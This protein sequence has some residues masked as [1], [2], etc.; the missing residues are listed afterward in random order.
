MGLNF[1]T[2]FTEALNVK[3]FNYRSDMTEVESFIRTY[4]S[5]RGCSLIDIKILANENKTRKIVINYNTPDGGESSVVLTI[6]EF[7]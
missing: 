1:E 7:L 2:E 3:N 5:E 6:N 4:Y